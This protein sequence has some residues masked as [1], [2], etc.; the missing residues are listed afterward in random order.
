MNAVFTQILDMSITASFM[1]AAIL[2]IRPLTG[3]VSKNIN[4][5]LWA[6][7]GLRLV[8]PFSF[9]TRVSAVPDIQSL[10]PEI[11]P[12]V[13]PEIIPDVVPTLP[14]EPVAQSNSID[15]LSVLWIVWLVGIA[16]LSVYTLVS[17]ILIKKKTAVSLHENENIY[18]CDNIKGA[19]I[20]GSFKPR[21]YIPSSTLAEQKQHVIAHENAHIKR[22]DYLWKP[23]GLFVAI[24]H[25]FNPLV[26]VG[27]ILLCRDIELACDEA[28]TRNMDVDSKKS[29]TR[30]LLDCAVAGNRYRPSP[31]AFGEVGVRDRIK[32]ILNYRK[33]A[34]WVSFGVI[35]ICIVIAVMFMTDPIV[36]AKLPDPLP[37]IMAEDTE[38]IEKPEPTE[39][40]EL[41]EDTKE[42]ETEP[43]ESEEVE[44][45]PEESDTTAEDTTAEDT[46]AEDTTA[47]DTTT[48]DTTTADT[49]TKDTTAKDTA[50]APETSAPVTDKP[51]A[52]KKIKITYKSADG[53]TLA[54][55]T[56]TA[57]EKTQLY[58]TDIPG[59]F[60]MGWTNYDWSKEVKYACGSYAEFYGDVTLYAVLKYRVTYN[61]NGGTP[62]Q[63]HE[64]LYYG[65][66]IYS[67]G[68]ATRDGYKFLGWWSNP[69]GGSSKRPDPTQGHT[70]LYAHWRIGNRVSFIYN[71]GTGDTQSILVEYGKPMGT[72]PTPTREGYTFNG[73]W[74]K[75]P[76][77]GETVQI[78]ETSLMPIDY[79]ISLEAQWIEN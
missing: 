42:K 78:T 48:A 39:T 54:V 52:A 76:I 57:G 35:A 31:L 19:F 72:L 1:I 16:L 53:S 18:I 25:W 11:V 24:L 41:P 13:T 36:N 43:T 30:A 60:M 79:D 67:M 21:I 49:T 64:D 32:N 34:F 27:Y 45:K 29:Y 14:A 75:Y 46:T 28:V 38:E 8:L 70:T 15:I 9:K 20:L 69:E 73:W 5:I 23:L 40:E 33:P 37:E 10:T 44:T 51:A 61:G 3:K 22:L 59:F 63:T 47:E 58:D 56:A 74:F 65:E 77:T 68:Y 12:E 7:A 17:F 6:L 71:G 4:C 55:K 62:S 2:L 50:K 26:W 66:E